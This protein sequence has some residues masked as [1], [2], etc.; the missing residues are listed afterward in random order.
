MQTVWIVLVCAAMVGCRTKDLSRRQLTE[1]VS[2][3]PPSLHQSKD[4]AEPDE[5]LRRGRGTHEPDR[6]QTIHKFVIKQ[7]PMEVLWYSGCNQE[8]ARTVQNEINNF[9]YLLFKNYIRSKIAFVSCRAS[10]WLT[11]ERSSARVQTF[12]RQVNADGSNIIQLAKEDLSPGGEL[13][14]FFS[15]NSAKAVVMTV[16]SAAPKSASSFIK[17]IDQNWADQAPVHFFG[18][19]HILITHREGIHPHYQALAAGLRGEF[20]ALHNRPIAWPIYLLNQVAAAGIELT[21]TTAYPIAEIAAVR[22]NDQPI[23]LKHVAYRSNEI[24]LHPS[25]A[26]ANDEVHVIYTIDAVNSPTP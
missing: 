1:D 6:I 4:L 18:L 13:A 16:D 15:P 22:I 20:I 17:L 5:L 24:R 19:Y 23:S 8:Y 12:N 14:E 11:F 2:S 7:K 10:S 26:R 25:V 3:G 9:S 21:S